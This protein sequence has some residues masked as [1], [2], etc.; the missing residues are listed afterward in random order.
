MLSA[1]QAIEYRY[2]LDFDRQGLSGIG[3]IYTV[4]GAASLWRRQA[5]V[6][7]GGFSDRTLA[8]DTDATISL[9]ARGWRVIALAGTTAATAVPS[10]LPMLVRQRIRLLIWGPL[11]VSVRQALAVAGGGVPLSH[12]GIIFGILSG[13]NFVGFV[14]PLWGVFELALGRLHATTRYTILAVFL[15][16]CVRLAI[17]LWFRDGSLARLPAL[18]GSTLLIQAINT[19]SFWAGLFAAAPFRRRWR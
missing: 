19:F 2:Q 16:G 1:V 3:Q 4:P 14:L 15:I 11:Q 18:I 17:A 8:E 6:E 5:L 9:R 7:I 13:L 12:P 10:T